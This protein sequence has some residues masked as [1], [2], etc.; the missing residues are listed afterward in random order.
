MKDRWMRVTSDRASMTLDKAEKLWPIYREHLLV[1]HPEATSLKEWMKAS[2]I[3][4]AKTRLCQVIRR[5]QAAQ[6]AA[7]TANKDRLEMKESHAP[8]RSL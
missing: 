5:A 6:S 4:K 3:S 7:L 2:G 1:T 8:I